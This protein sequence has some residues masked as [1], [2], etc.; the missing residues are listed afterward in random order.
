MD[1][2]THFSEQPLF[3]QVIKLLY[4]SKFLQISRPNGGEHYVKRFGINMMTSRSTLSDANKMDYS[5][6]G[7]KI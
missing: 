5:I 6:I 7:L 1:K 4:K 3:S 2:S